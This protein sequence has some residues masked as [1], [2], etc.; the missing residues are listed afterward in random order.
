ME[1]E[2]TED[3]KGNEDSSKGAGA[4][5]EIQELLTSFSSV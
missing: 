5:S 3:N 4:E 1:G 2:L